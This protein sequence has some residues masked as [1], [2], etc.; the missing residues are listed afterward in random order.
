MKT[1]TFLFFLLF[2]SNVIFAQNKKEQIE[3]LTKRVDSLK[4]V[5]NNVYSEKDTLTI[6]LFNVNKEN[7]NLSSEIKNLSNQL[8]SSQSSIT[9][10]KNQNEN[11]S[12]QIKN[13]Q[14]KI[15]S[16]E[17]VIQNKIIAKEDSISRNINS[18]Y[19]QKQESLYINTSSDK[20]S[21]NEPGYYIPKETINYRKH[22]LLNIYIFPSDE[23]DKNGNYKINFITVKIQNITTKKIIE[24]QIKKFSH[25][26]NNLQ[27]SFNCKELGNVS[28]NA[29]F[30][31]NNPTRNNDSTDDI[32]L[33]GILEYNNDFKKEIG[34]IFYYGD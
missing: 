25:N 2:I 4:S 18:A 11:Q 32:V 33:K 19:F 21:Y 22:K 3:I 10:L 8:S 17:F 28:L 23:I 31:G 26:N 13:F 14:I 27:F 30:I 20:M 16:L 6:K 9:I 12:T 24:T 5:L 29:N 34:F 15:D 1:N 7:I